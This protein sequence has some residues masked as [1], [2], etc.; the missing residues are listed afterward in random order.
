LR[1]L[2]PGNLRRP[3][4]ECADQFDSAV[5]LFRALRSEAGT[6]MLTHCDLV[7][8]GESAKFQMPSSICRG[9]GIWI[10]LHRSGDDRHIRA[11][12]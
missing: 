8:A 9:A 7:Y 4:Y 1:I 3:S 6:T 12:S 5:E 10:E 11:R 2:Q